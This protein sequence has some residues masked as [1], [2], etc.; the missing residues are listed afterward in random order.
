[1]CKGNVKVKKGKLLVK[2]LPKPKKKKKMGS[3]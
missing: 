3:V 1:M 2:D